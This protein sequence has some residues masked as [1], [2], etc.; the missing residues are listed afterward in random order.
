MARPVWTQNPQPPPF[1]TLQLWVECLWL[2][3]LRSFLYIA[4]HCPRHERSLSSL[5]PSHCRPTTILF[6]IPPLVTSWS[7]PPLAVAG[8]RLYDNGIIEASTAH[9]T[10]HIRN[11]SGER[12]V[13]K[14]AAAA[15]RGQ[16]HRGRSYN[17]GRSWIFSRCML[18]EWILWLKAVPEN[19]LALDPLPG[20][21]SMS[22]IML[23]SGRRI[24][25]ASGKLMCAQDLANSQKQALNTTEVT[26]SP[27]LSIQH[28]LGLPSS[29]P[30]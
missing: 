1:H 23:F 28:I 12:I 18:E 30:A 9:P 29:S 19:P 24:A 3:Q 20:W 26:Q 7:L 4:S 6:A 14:Q 15:W 8:D 13:Q 2:S 16:L 21:D 25:V 17:L 5:L 10:H 27:S 11:G 22:R